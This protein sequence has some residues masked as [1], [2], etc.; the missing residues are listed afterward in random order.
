MKLQKRLAGEEQSR[1]CVCPVNSQAGSPIRA[2][3]A[4]YFS[5]ETALGHSY[6]ARL[7]PTPHN[8]IDWVGETSRRRRFLSL[9]TL[10]VLAL[11][12]CRPARAE[13]GG[14]CRA[15]VTEIESGRGAGREL[16]CLIESQTAEPTGQMNFKAETR[17]RGEKTELN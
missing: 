13:F 15:G 8:L 14:H 5:H 10:K 12:R 7:A 6:P 16:E 1:R 11:A 17:R 3:F 9:A 4:S 2:S